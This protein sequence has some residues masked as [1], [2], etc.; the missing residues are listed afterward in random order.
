MKHPITVIR[1]LAVIAGLAFSGAALADDVE[2]YAIDNTHSF[3][4]F[5]LRH[6]V[7]KTSGS[8][9]DIK[10]KIVIDRSNLAKSEVEAR[11][12]VLSVNTNHAKRDEHIRDKAEYLD[13][14]KY[15]QI[16][17]IST[18]VEARGKDEGVLRGNLTMHG[19]TKEVALPFKLLGFGSDPWGGQRA[20]FEAHT[21]IK[22]SDY[23]FGW[24]ATPNGPV[25]N[26]IEITLLI[27]GIKSSP[28]YKPWN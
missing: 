12:N 6:V 19:V 1:Q 20:G 3:A 7:S 24:A 28:D 21:T 14:G 26:E 4:N 16:H 27:E 25:G 5:S 15:G 9:P 18:G 8:F 22:A 13:A 23:G 11:I 17:F 10:G 2:T